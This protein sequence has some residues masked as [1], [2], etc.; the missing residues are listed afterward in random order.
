MT[1]LTLTHLLYMKLVKDHMA[2]GKV[3]QRNIKDDLLKLQQGGLA[4]KTL[5]MMSNRNI[6]DIVKY[7]RKQHLIEHGD[8][9][10]TPQGIAIVERLE[11]YQ[12]N[13]WQKVT[14]AAVDDQRKVTQLE[15]V[16]KLN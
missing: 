16:V 15:V 12:R 9:S 1:E 14:R 13:W 5:S 8:Q 6:S 4:T 3:V 11:Q 2:S 7:L 10:L